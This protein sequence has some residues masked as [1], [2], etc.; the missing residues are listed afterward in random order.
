M[1]GYKAL[2]NIIINYVEIQSIEK[3]GE[4]TKIIFHNNEVI[5]IKKRYQAIIKQIQNVKN[6]M[7]HMK[8][9][10]YKDFI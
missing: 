1:F 2:D 10:S 6:M 7:T 9:F 8:S 4:K 5:Y 3:D